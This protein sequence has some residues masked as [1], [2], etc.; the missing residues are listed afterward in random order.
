[1][2]RYFRNLFWQLDPEQSHQLVLSLLKYIPPSF[3]QIPPQNPVEAMGIIFPHAVGLAP[4]LDSN[5]RYIE[6]LAKLGAAFIEL[7]GVT[8]KPQPGN[9]KPR[10][11]RLPSMHALINR[12]GF[13]NEGVDALA[14]RLA[15]TQY[16]GILGVNIA[17]NKS[18]SLEDAVNDFIYCMQ[19]IY[20]Y[21]SYITVNI[22][23][24][25]MPH[26]RD[27]Q[28]VEYFSNLMNQLREEQLHL[29]D[30]HGK[31]VPLVVKLSP[32]ESNESL[33]RLA[34]TLASLRIDGIAA[35]NTT[36]NRDT[37]HDLPHGLEVGGLSGRPL[38]M[39]ATECIQLIRQEVG[40]SMTLM[41]VGGIDNVQ[42]AQERVQAGAD[43]LQIYTGLIYEGP[44]LI[45]DIVQGLQELRA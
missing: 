43:L 23:S 7:G 33:K 5:G 44:S 45:N 39:R 14:L 30:V 27:L 35:T 18:T 19:K 41:G 4:G 28:K 21:A 26:L 34:G 31:Y 12:M 1:M 37:V 36:V 15:K 42:L 25:N 32:D 22:S 3:F 11:F 24:P 10:L 38:A 8:P 9:P 20:A 40:N 13:D 17:K 16:S 2:Y 6:A 29:A